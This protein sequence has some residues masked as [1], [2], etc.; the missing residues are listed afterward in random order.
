MLYP[1]TAVWFVPVAPT[2]EI[3]IS[4]S[5]DLC[6]HEASICS[7]TPWTASNNFSNQIK[8]C[9]VKSQLITPPFRKYNN[10]SKTMDANL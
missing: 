4:Y 10:Q 3:N 9:V 7:Q 5:G 2:V 6:I 8:I 1:D